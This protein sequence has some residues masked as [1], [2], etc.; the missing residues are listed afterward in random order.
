MTREE[1]YKYSKTGVKITDDFRNNLII[2]RYHPEFFNMRAGKLSHMQSEN[3]EDVVTWNVFHSLR[4]IKPEIWAPSLY[5]KA[6]PGKQKADFEKYINSTVIN[7]WKTVPPPPSLVEEGDEGNS[8]IDICMESPNWVWFIEA[9]LTGDISKRTTIRENR[10]QIIRNIDVGSYY[11]GVRDFYFSLLIK[12]EKSS[13][14]GVKKIQEYSTF[15]KAHEILA[16]HRPDKLVN[17]KGIST[18]QWQHIGE[19]LHKANITDQIE[20]T[21]SERLLK[22]MEGKKLYVK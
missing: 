4:Q 16:E 3:S 8:E 10:D 20:N 15:S 11:A 5:S 19:I 12:S 1:D 6:F 2:D 17:L 7:L 9:K 13:K 22:W 18:I 14:N 21:F